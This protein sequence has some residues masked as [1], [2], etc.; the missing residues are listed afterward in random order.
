MNYSMTKPYKKLALL[1]K[2]S[3]I[4]ILMSMFLSLIPLFIFLIT[5]KNKLWIG[6]ILFIVIW[7][8]LCILDYIVCKRLINK[9]N[10]KRAKYLTLKSDVCSFEN[11]STNNR[12]DISTDVSIF[13]YNERMLNTVTLYRMTENG[14]LKD[15]RKQ[16]QCYLKDNY[17]EARENNASKKHHELKVQLYAIEG[18]DDVTCNFNPNF[19]QLLS[20]GY[21]EAYWIMNKGLI[22]L[23]MYTGKELE[24]S[25]LKTYDKAINKLIDIFNVKSIGEQNTIV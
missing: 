21:I 19:E 9:E 5:D 13:V 12:I 15:M 17:K 18:D 3:A 7:V 22:V 2:L 6:G 14:L 23:R 1:T 11:L 8:A 24:L 25:S 4:V 16:S 20:I 10:E